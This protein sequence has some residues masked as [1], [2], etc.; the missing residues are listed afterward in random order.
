MGL[1]DV[2][3]ENDKEERLLIFGDCKGWSLQRLGFD[4]VHGTSERKEG[5]SPGF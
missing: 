5:I 3:D 2:G 4:W 1:P